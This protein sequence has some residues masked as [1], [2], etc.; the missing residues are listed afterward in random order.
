MT[1]VLSHIGI[2]L[3]S[4]DMCDTKFFT[5]WQ[6]TL[7]R[8]DGIFENNII[9][10]PNE[11]LSGKLGLFPGAASP[12]LKC[13]ACGKALGK[14]FHVVRGHILDHLNLKGQACSICDQCHL[15]LCSLMW[16]TLIWAFRFSPVESVPVAL[17][18]G[19]F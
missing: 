3:F 9:V 10:H 5:Q 12:E 1:L 11:P 18:T 2:F 13:A 17:W 8:R 16:H 7:H 4:C 15:N 19:T 14:D 6:L